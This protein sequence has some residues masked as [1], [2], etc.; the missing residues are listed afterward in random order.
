DHRVADAVLHARERVEELELEQDLGLRAV[1]GGGAV[2]P[3]E[4]RATDDLGNVVVDTGHV[5]DGFGLDENQPDWSGR[6]RRSKSWRSRSTT[7]EARGPAR[8][9]VTSSP[10]PAARRSRSRRSLASATASRQKAVT[11]PE[12][13]AA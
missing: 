6:K 9:K 11:G 4:G 10:G 12:F 3:D 5:R 13:R 1:D 7:S 2:E 8:V